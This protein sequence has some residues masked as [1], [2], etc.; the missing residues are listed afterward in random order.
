M[1]MRYLDRNLI[2]IVERKKMNEIVAGSRNGRKVK[3]EKVAKGRQLSLIKTKNNKKTSQ[4][5]MSHSK[6]PIEN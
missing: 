3:S 6:D 4:K 1:L 2:D 5:Q